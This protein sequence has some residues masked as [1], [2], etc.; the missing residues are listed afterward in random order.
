M[1]VKN[2][3]K[4]N[5]V[6]VSKDVNLDQLTDKF[7]KYNFHTL[8]VTDCNNKLLGIVSYEDLMKVFHPYDYALKELKESTREY[9]T[10]QSPAMEYG[11]QEDMGSTVMVSDIMDTNVVAVKED[12]TLI[13]VRTLMKRS[14]VAQI[15]V[16]K[17]N[18]LVGIITLFDII[19]SIFKV[20]NVIK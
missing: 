5:V 1:R 19:I 17:D 12:E 3:M 10:T 18:T 2:I 6:T 7:I 16:I 11:F 14:G 8:P 20:M 13:E 4:R 15:P 9:N